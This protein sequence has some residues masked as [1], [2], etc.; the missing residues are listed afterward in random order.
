MR[1]DGTKMPLQ[2]RAPLGLFYGALA[3]F[4]ESLCPTRRKLIPVNS[5]RTAGIN[6][7]SGQTFSIRIVHP[8]VHTRMPNR[9]L[10]LFAHPRLE[11]SRA[12]RALLDAIAGVDQLTLHDLYEEYPEFNIDIRREQQL[13]AS[14]DIIVWQHPIFWYSAPPLLKQWIDLVLEHGWAYGHGGTALAGKRVFNAVSSG[15]PREAYTV[16]GYHG[17]TLRQFL[18]PFQRTATL[19]HMDYLPP[20]AM[21]GVNRLSAEGVR[22]AAAQYRALLER[23]AAGDFDVEELHRH[24]YLNDWLASPL[25][26]PQA[27]VLNTQSALETAP[28]ASVDPGAKPTED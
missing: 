15:G 6:Y 13:L 11:K 22:A 24:E 5:G 28:S 12:Q 10:L 17:Y 20:F 1:S 4:T 9:I 14:H 16:E 21:L 7:F 25:I 27:S 23:L 26:S 19:C 3:L 18:L 8:F 2:N